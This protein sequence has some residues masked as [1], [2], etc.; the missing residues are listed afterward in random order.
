M[1]KSPKLT[2]SSERPQRRA[3]RLDRKAAL[4]QRARGLSTTEIAVLQRVDRST[5][6]RFL[7]RAEPERQAV[8]GF[9]RGRADAFVRLQIKSLDAQERLIDSLTDEV[10]NALTPHQKSAL[11]HSLNAQ[12]GTLFDKERL[13]TGKS[14]ATVSLRQIMARA[15]QD[16]ANPACWNEGQS[17]EEAAQDDSDDED[18]HS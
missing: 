7:A 15:F 14:T 11:L 10:L 16:L 18:A 3:R 2:T 12:S 4:E 17:D 8:E 6:R 9:K 5:V 1:I 13:E